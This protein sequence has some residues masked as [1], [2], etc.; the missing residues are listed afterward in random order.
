[1]IHLQ[2]YD[3]NCSITYLRFTIFVINKMKKCEAVCVFYAHTNFR[4]G[5]LL[6]VI[7]RNTEPHLTRFLDQVQYTYKFY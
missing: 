6:K 4:T 2:N 5:N 1:M 7:S 3:R